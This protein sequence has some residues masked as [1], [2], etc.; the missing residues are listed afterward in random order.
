MQHNLHQ[1]VME[2]MSMID[3][4]TEDQ[5][6]C[7]PILKEMLVKKAAVEEELNVINKEKKEVETQAAANEFLVTKTVANKEVWD[8]TGLGTIGESRIRT[9]REPKSKLR[10]RFQNPSF[11]K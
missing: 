6:W 8:N 9:T 2:E 3:A 7:M 5:V 4:T 11:N 1:L 10:N